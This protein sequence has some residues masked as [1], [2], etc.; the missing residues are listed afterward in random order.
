MTETKHDSA[1]SLFS[2]KEALALTGRFVCSE[3]LAITTASVDFVSDVAVGHSLQP[4]HR[5]HH[6]L[7]LQTDQNVMGAGTMSP[8][9]EVKTIPQQWPKS[10]ESTAERTV[11]PLLHE[12]WL[13]CWPLRCQFKPV[14]LRKMQ[15]AHLPLQN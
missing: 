14:K 9:G 12:R 5:A 7:S 8:A 3:E 6:R 2:G 4:R 13:N 11:N 15:A 1:A 10:K